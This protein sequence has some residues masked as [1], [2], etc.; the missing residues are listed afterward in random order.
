MITASADG[1]TLAIVRYSQKG[2]AGI[3]IFDARSATT[4]AQP[5]PEL[6]VIVDALSA[7]GSTIYAR[8]WPPSQIGAERLLLDARSGK[9]VSREP[10]IS[11]GADPI[12][13]I[14]MVEERRL[15]AL[16]VQSDSNATGPR[17]VEVGAWDLRTGRELWR[18]GV[19][20]LLA[21]DWGSGQA[22]SDGTVT[23]FGLVPGFALSPDG[24]QLAIVRAF[25]CC[26]AS[27]TLWLANTSGGEILSQRAYQR[28]AS[29]LNRLF[30]SSVAAAKEVNQVVVNASF[31]ADGRVLHVYAQ[32]WQYDGGAEPYQYLGM[33]A[34][35]VATPKVLG[36]DIKMEQWWYQNKI[37]WLR[38][39]P[40]GRWVYV[41]LERTG[42]ADPKGYVLRR[43][44]ARSLSVLAARAFDS[45]RYSVI[46]AAP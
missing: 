39:S 43:L 40:D 46:L 19:P 3:S 34:L 15:Y 2:A 42:N 14:T 8:E 10:A 7:D 35:D 4:A 17:P 37:L 21:G 28:D 25:D 20:S 16:L 45:F 23:R 32:S 24:R 13:W 27:G 44:D 22:G 11:F 29:L 33:S 31:G 6:P 36:S 41:F 1:G 26:V 9:V 12:T 18:H 5:S 30:G 38:P